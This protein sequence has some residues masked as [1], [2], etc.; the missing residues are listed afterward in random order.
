MLVTNGCSFV[1]G[2]ELEGYDND[3]PTH[4]P[5]TFTHLLADK[6]EVEY[7]NLGC[8]GNGN[9][10]I[11]RDTSDYLINC[12]ELPTHMV[13]L[14]SAWQREEIAELH[15]NE[16]DI[17]IERWENMTQISPTRLGHMGSKRVSKVLDLLY[18]DYDNTRTG[19]LHGLTYMTHMQWLC[20]KLDIKLVQGVFHERS[21]EAVCE[22]LHPNEAKGKV[23]WKQW[24]LSV[25][26]KLGYLDKKSRVGMNRYLDFYSIA[27]KFNDVKPYG[28]PGERSHKEFADLL[29]H[30]FESEFTW[31]I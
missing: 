20:E 6:L 12:N 18:D 3:P 15:Y 11:F 27:E 13:I 9:D 14:W 4:W 5:L 8:C 2:D 24:M 23:S 29:Y 25:N 17:K 7:K 30:I 1:W 28:H 19:I 22:T 10:K 16:S 21:W 31:K 26:K